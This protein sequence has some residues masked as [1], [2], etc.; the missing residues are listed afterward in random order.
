MS[1]VSSS[2][3]CKMIW[4]FFRFFFLNVVALVCLLSPLV[5]GDGTGSAAPEGA[6]GGVILRWTAPGDDG[7]VG[8]ATGYEVRYHPVAFGPIDTESEW[9]AA[10][11]AHDLPFPSLAG[12]KDSA[13]ILGLTPGAG[14]Y[15][16]LKTYDDAY[17][18]SELSNSPLVVAILIDC[19]QG[20]VGNVSGQNW[21]EPTLSDVMMLVDHVFISGRSLWCAAEADID[22][23]GGADPQQGSNGDITLIDIMMLVDHIF[24]TGR[25]LPDCIH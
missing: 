1:C 7:R 9:Q 13:M 24:L 21:G 25:P 19:C 6:S 4:L 11:R 14:Y 5:L 10:S 15:F 8:R 23:S 3:T 20:K 18:Y 12:S 2:A 22:Q 16:A 17:N